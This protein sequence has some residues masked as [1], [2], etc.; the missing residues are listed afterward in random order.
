MS[1][2]LQDWSKF[3]AAVAVSEPTPVKEDK[4]TTVRR[5]SE[6]LRASLERELRKE[7]RSTTGMTDEVLGNIPSAE[8]TKRISNLEK[9]LGYGL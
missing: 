6:R 8:L 1:Y 2:Y 9:L 7:D 3:R 4:I 5:D